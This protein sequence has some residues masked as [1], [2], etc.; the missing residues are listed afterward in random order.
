MNSSPI[1]GLMHGCRIS[2]ASKKASFASTNDGRHT[3]SVCMCTTKAVHQK[4]GIG[5][6][7]KR[8]TAYRPAKNW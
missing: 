2:S 6:I 8:E 3:G 4:V 1:L 7:V 5:V